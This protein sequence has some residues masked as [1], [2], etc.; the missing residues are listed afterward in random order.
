MDG[1]NCVN[2]I[3]KIK[4]KNNID[5]LRKHM[6]FYQSCRRD[7]NKKARSASGNY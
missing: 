4:N 2:C 1:I 5:N 6:I 3:N 7:I